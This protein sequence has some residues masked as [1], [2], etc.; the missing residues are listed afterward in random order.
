MDYDL[1]QP[2]WFNCIVCIIELRINYRNNLYAHHAYQ[3][4]TNNVV[5]Q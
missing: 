4:W 5:N 1:N 2:E 3:Q